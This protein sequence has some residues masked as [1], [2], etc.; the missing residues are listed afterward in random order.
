M[1]ELS[2]T[3]RLGGLEVAALSDGVGKQ[4]P[5]DWFPGVP[6]Q[7]WVAALGLRAEVETLPV[8][9]G[10]F[11]VRGDG[12]T[13]LI[14]TGNG[15]RARGWHPGGG[16][17]LD[18]MR[19]LGV[20][21]GDVDAVLLT[22]FHG[23]HVGWNL[24]DDDGAV[25]FPNARYYLHQADVAYLDDPKTPAS[26][27]ADFSRSRIAP[28]IDAGRLDSFDGEYSPRPGLVMVPTP[29]HT[30]GHC[31]VL[32]ES[33]GERLFVVGDAAPNVA[34]LEHPEW[35]PVFDLD[36]PR[37]VASR[38]ALGERAIR[39]EALVTGGHFPILTVG[40][41]ERAGD[42]VRWSDVAVERVA[43]PRQG[44]LKRLG[45]LVGRS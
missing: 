36:G 12:R 7:E 24:E 31:S 6:A 5:S 42:G 2:A 15:A 8:N 4:Q 20:A 21:P 22:H 29:G 17:L 27:G 23:D 44:L 33:Q 9:F 26:E 16:G 28:L 30:P 45:R 37:A 1:P 13:T 40:R 18:R 35:T 39:D 32:I 11:L 25:T 34:H 14:D 43:P 10:S 41:L 3:F 38:R 19:E